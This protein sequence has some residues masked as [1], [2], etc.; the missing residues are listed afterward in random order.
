[1]LRIRA[2]Y[3]DE[4][5]AI[6]S[7]PQ[8]NW[9]QVCAC[10]GQP[11]GG[12]VYQLKHRARES[13]GGEQGAAGLIFAWMT[14]GFDMSWPVPCCQACQ[15]HSRK[16][17]NPLRLKWTILYAGI[18]TMFIGGFALWSMGVANGNDL[19]DDPVG[20]V[21]A[22]GFVCL[23]FLAWYGVWRL[24]G[25][26]MRW[27]GRGSTTPRCADSL[28]PVAAGSD[29]RFVRFDFTNDAYARSVAQANGLAT[30]PARFTKVPVMVGDFLIRLGA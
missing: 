21:V 3:T 15:V 13:S 18:A 23:N 4:K 5:S 30:E 25:G 10:C 27:R 8:V 22:I 7:A 9:P 14:S 20:S 12:A 11:N 28:A 1:M 29:A 6:T 16:S 26:L 17:H 24:A 2:P 19:G